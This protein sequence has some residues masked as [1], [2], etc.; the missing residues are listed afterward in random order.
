MSYFTQADLADDGDIRRRVTACA[1]LEGVPAPEAFAYNHR[2]ELS[3]QPD[4][5]SAYESAVANSVERPGRDPAVIS[6]TQ[7]LSAVQSINAPP[8]TEYPDPDPAE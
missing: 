1:A 3:A 6:D 8:P 7:I 4:W 2:W 5:D